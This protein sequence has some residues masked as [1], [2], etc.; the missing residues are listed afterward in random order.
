MRYKT[1]MPLEVA[2][3]NDDHDRAALTRKPWSLVTLLMCGRLEA[4]TLVAHEALPGHHL[5]VAPAL[6]RR[7]SSALPHSSG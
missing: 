2:V 5:Q 6:H 1:S 7:R 4:E 3:T